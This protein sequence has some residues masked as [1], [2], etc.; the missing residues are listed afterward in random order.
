MSILS[1]EMTSERIIEPVHP[2]A[3]AQVESF[4]KMG[5]RERTLTNK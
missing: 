1:D 3:L 4:H 2:A 5:L